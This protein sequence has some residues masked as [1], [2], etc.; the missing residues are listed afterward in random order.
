LLGSD[1]GLPYSS[2]SK[3]H[4]ANTLGLKKLSYQ[5]SLGESIHYPVL[6]SKVGLDSAISLKLFVGAS[7][8]PKLTKLCCCLNGLA[9][10]CI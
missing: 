7:C 1:V 8:T 2:A 9:T 5:A 10:L 3:S 4:C 6:K